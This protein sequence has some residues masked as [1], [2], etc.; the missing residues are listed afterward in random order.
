MIFRSNLYYKSALFLFLIIILFSCEKYNLVRSNTHDPESIYFEPSVPLIKIDDASEI[1]ANG[2]TISAEITMDGGASVTSR[3]ICWSLA[4]NPTTDDFKIAEGAGTGAY[5]VS[6]TGLSQGVTYYIRAYS[7][8]SVGTSYSLQKNI[9]TLDIPKVYTTAVTS[10]K[11]TSSYAGGTVSSDG[12]TPLIERGLCWS[13][14]EHPT[15][16]NFKTN[17]G[18]ALGKFTCYMMDLIPGQKYFFR[19]YAINEI[20]IAYGAEF[21]FIALGVGDKYQGGI[22]AYLF[23]PGNPGYV[24]NEPHGLI[25]TASD[26]S[27]GVMWAE[28]S[29]SGTSV[30]LGTGNSNT[31]FI[32]GTQ[33]EGNYAAKICYDLELNGFS[34]WYLPSLRDLGVIYPNKKLIG[35][36]S[37]ANYWS[38]YYNTDNEAWT[39]SFASG[40]LI[41]VSIKG[42]AYV[43]A[44][45]SF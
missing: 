17:E 29:V 23:K 6:I 21:N 35:G 39:F 40:E 45:R 25:I 33:G 9:T 41:S 37:D 11:A 43:R 26:Q 2:I 19:A 27:T 44:V 10:I 12:G 7:T 22:V 13:T 4:Q 3:G 28:V 38:S 34:D 30:D 1:K 20:G 15:I 36:L 31:N 5:S 16:E 24:E 42:T 14:T 8:N 18:H 32:V